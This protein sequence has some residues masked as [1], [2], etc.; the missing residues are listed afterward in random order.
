MSKTIAI[1]AGSSSLKWQLYQM[2]EETVIG[3][4]IIERIGLPDSISTVKFGSKKQ[5]TIKDIK[6]HTEAVQILM[7]DL[8]D[9]GIIADYAEITGSGHRVVAGGEIFNDSVVIN[10]EVAKQI[11]D[12]AE[13]APL[14][15]P[16]NAAGI[17]AFMTLLPNATHVA[18]FDTAFH[19][20]MPA[21]AYRYPVPD[22]Y[23]TE[24]GVRKYGA[25]GTSH[26]YVSQKAAEMLGKPL[27]ELKIITA[28]IGNGAS[29]TA[30]DGGKSIDT[31]MGFTPLAGVMMGT[32]SGDLDPSIIPFIMEKEG[33]ADITEMISILNKASGLQGISGISSDM[34][35]ITASW[36]AGEARGVLAFEMFVDRI[37]KYIG[38]YFAVLNGADALV[39]TAGIGENSFFVRKA[40]IDG[41]S[42]FGL[43]IVDDLNVVGADGIIS[44]ENAKVKV[45][46]IPTDEEL[47]IARDVEKLKK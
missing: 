44:S 40:V 30:V 25:H 15:N 9:L 47:V 8:I 31:S 46:V 32:R 5:E 21:V 27:E 3:K 42:W 28:H 23:Y 43:D 14:H 11:A 16:A 36:E 26:M 22:K 45:L 37:K 12:L 19:S 35:E 24:H 18:V 13:Y 6:D 4:G 41:L 2:P 34:R 7:N 39:F 33:I 17:R 29:I 38:Q 10:D 1:N 20:T